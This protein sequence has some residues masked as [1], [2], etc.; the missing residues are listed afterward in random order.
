MG[1]AMHFGPRPV[2]TDER[3]ARAIKLRREGKTHS[4]IAR[5]LNCGMTRNA[6]IGK[7]ERLVKAGLAPDLPR[8]AS[9]AKPARPKVPAKAEPSKPAALPKSAVLDVGIGDVPFAKRGRSFNHQ[10]DVV[11]RPQVAV[12]PP[13]PFTNGAR[14]G[15]MQLTSQTCKWPIGDPGTEEFCF[16]GHAPRAK[17]PYCEYHAR[18]AYVP[19][20]DRRKAAAC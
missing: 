15:V 18:A 12:K 4:E 7:L 17:S 13:V 2:W 20:Q 1:E 16:C 10:T 6:V 5:D 9:S 8:V 14:I 11:K 19:L 3:I